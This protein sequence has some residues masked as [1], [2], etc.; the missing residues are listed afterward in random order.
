[1]ATPAK[2]YKSYDHPD[3]IKNDKSISK[4]QKITLL[5]NWE[6]DEEAI[7]RAIDEGM[8]SS[9]VSPM[10]SVVQKALF[11]IQAEQTHETS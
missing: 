3:D 2:S 4:Q 7:E 8:D 6:T 9:A 11:D 5:Q 1:M 10:L